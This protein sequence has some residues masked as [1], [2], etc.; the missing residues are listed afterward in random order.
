MKVGGIAWEK[1]GDTVRETSRIV[2]SRRLQTHMQDFADLIDYRL[3]EA[4]RPF[5]AEEILVLSDRQF[6]S[7]LNRAYLIIKPITEGLKN[8]FGDCIGIKKSN[9]MGFTGY[10]FEY[11]GNKFWFGVWMHTWAAI[12]GSP[13]CLQIFQ[14]VPHDLEWPGG[15]S[16]PAE[17]KWNGRIMPIDI[18]AQVERDELT[19][20]IVKHIASIIRILNP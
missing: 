12:G 5:T 18:A 20:L 8:E 19:N 6:A 13:L 1:I 14:H 9:G 10:A 7:A 4:G 2:T 11:A 17:G 3:G 15:M 16:K